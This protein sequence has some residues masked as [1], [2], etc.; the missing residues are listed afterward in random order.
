MLLKLKVLRRKKLK[1]SKQK[2]QN[3]TILFENSLV[4]FRAF[5]SHLTRLH[6]LLRSNRISFDRIYISHKNRLQTLL[7]KECNTII[8]Y[9]QQSIHNLSIYISTPIHSLPSPPTTSFSV[10]S[11]QQSLKVF[12][13]YTKH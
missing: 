12:P 7:K 11:S 10:L 3:S 8:I 6:L 4:A 5:S 1:E 13:K 9:L 2:I